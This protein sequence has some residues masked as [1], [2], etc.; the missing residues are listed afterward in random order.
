MHQPVCVRALKSFVISH[1]QREAWLGLALVCTIDFT[2]LFL[3]LCHLSSVETLCGTD[4]NKN[5]SANIILARRCDANRF[6]IVLSIPVF[7]HTLRLHLSRF[8]A[9]R[10]QTKRKTF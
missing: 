9:K 8:V 4:N 6:L 2:F 10:I 7:D 3:F 5:D 1:T